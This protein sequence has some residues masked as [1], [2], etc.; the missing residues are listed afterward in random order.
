MDDFCETNAIF[1]RR[2]CRKF[3]SAFDNDSDSRQ[4]FAVKIVTNQRI[5]VINAASHICAQSDN[6]SYD[7]V[8]HTISQPKLTENGLFQQQK[9]LHKTINPNS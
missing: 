2:F 7:K 4:L 5:I 3:C 9:K 8:R 1:R 6:M